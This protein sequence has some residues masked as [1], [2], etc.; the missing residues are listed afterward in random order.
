MTHGAGVAYQLVIN[1]LLHVLVIYCH[2]EL[3]IHFSY[4]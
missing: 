1:L 4:N 3:P 2:F